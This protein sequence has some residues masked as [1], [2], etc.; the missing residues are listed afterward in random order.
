MLDQA[1]SILSVFQFTRKPSQTIYLQPDF[2]PQGV[3]GHGRKQAIVHIQKI[4]V[5]H[6]DQKRNSDTDS[7][8]SLYTEL[9]TVR[10]RKGL[11]EFVE[12]RQFT[13][14]PCEEESKK[15]FEVYAASGVKGIP[16][17]CALINIKTGNAPK[18]T[19]E[20]KE[21]I[22]K[23]RSANLDFLWKKIGEMRAFVKAWDKNKLEEH[24]LAWLNK[25]LELVSPICI[26]YDGYA[27]KGVRTMHSKMTETLEEVVGMRKAKSLK[28]IQG[29]RVYGHFA[30]CALELFHDMESSLQVFA[31][32]HCG[33]IR[34]REK[35]NKCKTCSREENAGCIKERQNERQEKSRGKGK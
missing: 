33:T 5:F 4:K 16:I 35:R 30:L 14:I 10:N 24:K 7:T 22:E 11:E 17:G 18:T 27:L 9:L 25:E 28:P 32:K 26:P 13:Y 31:C 19:T 6:M 8:D 23:I 1:G 3:L 2:Q 20:T 21:Q 34:K 15:L 12:E 29:Y